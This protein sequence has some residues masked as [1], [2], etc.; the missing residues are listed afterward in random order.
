MPP[1]DR[2]KFALS[3]AMP[4]NPIALACVI[5]L[6]AEHKPRYNGVLACSPGMSF[7]GLEL[8]LMLQVV[9]FLAAVA[10]VSWLIP[11][12][13]FLVRPKTRTPR[14]RLAPQAR[15]RATP[16]NAP[17]GNRAL[18]RLVELVEDGMPP[19]TDDAPS[20]SDKVVNLR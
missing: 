4:S 18:D 10:I 9:L 11:V 14:E 6:D 3:R 15:V 13:A 2:N 1:V 12:L 8:R 5:F 16:R 17:A 20:R 19:R 7:V